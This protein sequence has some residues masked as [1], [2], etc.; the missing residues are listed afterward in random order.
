MPDPGP[1]PMPRACRPAIPNTCKPSKPK[2]QP[3][4]GDFDKQPARKLEGSS[5]PEQPSTA[6]Q[7]KGCVFAKSCTLPDGIINFS[8]P[9]GFVPAEQLSQYGSY[10]ALA[11]SSAVSGALDWIGG[12]L[13]ATELAKR[14]GGSLSTMTP[15]N[16]K[17]L[18]GM[19][20]PNTTSADSAFYTFEQYAQLTQ[21][22][23]RVRVNVKY[24]PDGSVN[25]YGFYTGTKSA[26]QMV[27][28]IKALAEGEQLIADLGD[29]IKVIWTPVVDPSS[30]LGIP[31][32]EGA[33]LKP[34]AWV[35]PP[36][37]TAAEI[38]VNPV[39]PPDY[40]DAII[41]FPNTGI[42]P[43]YISLSLIGDHRYHSP[44]KDLIAFPDARRAKRK[45]SVQGGGGKR[46]RWIDRSGKIY[47][48]DSQHGMVEVYDKQGKHLGEF[49]PETGEQTKPAKP[50]R[51]TPK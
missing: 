50:G 15:P 8:T 5:K 23:T 47:E 30:A 11:T 29:D 17:I 24:L 27:P 7:F 40:K 33:S 9:S 14:L 38:L 37:D 6:P 13:S 3:Y 2:P 20:L 31:A 18:I 45:A 25:M 12:S 28:V 46:Y 1:G 51:T 48:W 35:Y 34:N 16:V 36:T 39:Y 22:N 49:D 43:V 41:W 26:W 44:P 19:L 4:N 42:Q 21:G 32:L 10:A